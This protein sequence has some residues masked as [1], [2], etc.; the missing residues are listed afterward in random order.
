MT[1][2]LTHQWAG[3][4][5]RAQK[6]ACQSKSAIQRGPAPS[7][8][9]PAASGA[10]SRARP[11][12][13]CMTKCSGR[14][15]RM[16]D[17]AFG[18]QQGAEHNSRFRSHGSHFTVQGGTTE[19]LRV[20]SGPPWYRASRRDF[21]LE[22]RANLPAM[23]TCAIAASNLC[24]FENNGRSFAASHDAMQSSFRGRGWGGR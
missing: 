3:P 10:P 9:P 4:R 8:G 20:S 18:R 1:S 12:P 19:R 24:N 16:N 11:G 15:G 22:T 21:D 2:W 5:H 17:D 6:G 14:A 7:P 13:L 23:L